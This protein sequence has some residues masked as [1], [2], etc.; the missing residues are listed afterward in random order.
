M[1]VFHQNFFIHTIHISKL[2]K[3]AFCL[4]SYEVKTNFKNIECTKIS[5]R[6]SKIKFKS[7]TKT[8][9]AIKY[10]TNAEYTQIYACILHIYL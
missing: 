4:L 7:K 5:Y 2:K 8:E 10:M 1:G 9:K 3:K 6:A